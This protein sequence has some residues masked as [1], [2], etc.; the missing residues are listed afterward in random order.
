[1]F[2][3]TKALCFLPVLLHL[4]H[5]KRISV[6]GFHTIAM[7]FPAFN[8]LC[9]H[10][11]S[12]S[13]GK[14]RKHNCFSYFHSKSFHNIQGMVLQVLHTSVCSIYSFHFHWWVFGLF[15]FIFSLFIL[16]FPF[17]VL[18]LFLHLFFFI[19]LMNVSI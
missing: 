11:C 18:I 6:V 1:M 5:P 14:P 7:H 16:F 8:V 2:L 10:C 17:L 3:T 13:N 15:P 9:V 4:E 12:G 19:I